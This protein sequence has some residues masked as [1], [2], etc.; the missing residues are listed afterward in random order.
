MTDL[1]KD[2]EVVCSV[3][4]DD[5]STTARRA[6]LSFAGLSRRLLQLSTINNK[7][8]QSPYSDRPPWP[9]KTH[10]AGEVVGG[11]P[12]GLSWRRRVINAALTKYPKTCLESGK[13]E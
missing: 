2:L 6:Y 1:E 13:R 9:V 5:V 11:L 3:A 4:A 8:A 7:S 10:P 12:W